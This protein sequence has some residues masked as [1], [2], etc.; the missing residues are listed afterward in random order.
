[1]SFLGRCLLL[2][3]A[4]FSRCGFPLSFV[5]LLLLL[6]PASCKSVLCPGVSLVGGELV[7]AHGLAVVL[8]QAAKAGAVKDPEIDLLSRNFQLSPKTIFRLRVPFFDRA[9]SDRRHYS[10]CRWS[11]FCVSVRLIPH[12][13]RRKSRC[14][15]GICW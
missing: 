6:P 14:A 9:K 3:P 1:L 10:V 5:F 4:P 11:A 7:E 8:R 2:P 13:G 15:I 12:D